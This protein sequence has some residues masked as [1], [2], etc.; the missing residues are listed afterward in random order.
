MKNETTMKNNEKPWKKL[1]KI[2]KTHEK[3]MA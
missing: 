1:R 3:I 2:M